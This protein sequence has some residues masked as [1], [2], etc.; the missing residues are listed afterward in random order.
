MT[1]D[2]FKGKWNQFKGDLKRQWGK[3]TDDD[4]MVIDGDYDKFVGVLQE[5][6]GWDRFQTKQE[7]DDYFAM[8]RSR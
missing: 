8:Q 2:V 5:R 3:I 6:Y 1:S 7:I 4:L